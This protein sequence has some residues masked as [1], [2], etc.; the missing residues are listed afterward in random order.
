MVDPEIKKKENTGL[1]DE[2][3]DY[4]KELIKTIETEGGYKNLQVTLE[5]VD[6]FVLWDF[7]PRCATCPSYY[8]RPESIL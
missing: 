3:I 6:N 2:M 4:C 5:F 1:L 8:K 7:Y